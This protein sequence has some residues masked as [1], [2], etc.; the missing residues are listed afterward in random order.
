MQY[1]YTS[2]VTG[3]YLWGAGEQKGAQVG[4]LISL[5]ATKK[6]S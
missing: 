3:L 1:K 6:N 2:V 4:N 5:N